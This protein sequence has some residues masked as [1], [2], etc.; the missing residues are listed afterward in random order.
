MKKQ[1]LLL[2][3]GAISCV[4]LT[5]CGKTE[6]SASEA[7]EIAR[8]ENEF[9][10]SE[11]NFLKVTTTITKY[12]VTSGNATI[13]KELL[14]KVSPIEVGKATTTSYKYSE[15]Y[16]DYIITKEAIAK[17]EGIDQVKFYKDGKKLTASSTLTQEQ[18]IAT[19]G[20]FKISTTAT[21]NYDANGYMVNSSAVIDMTFTDS[22][23]SSQ[24]IET[25]IEWIK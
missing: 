25:S 20:T 15:A 23:T 22:S 18:E 8:S 17:L 13:Y 12:D 5:S 24:V 16:F 2:V 21:N 1:K 4:A 14:N 9:E 7:K 6:I 11:Y 10:T 19:F 3:L